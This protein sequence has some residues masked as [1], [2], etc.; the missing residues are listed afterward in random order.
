I[1][2]QPTAVPS[3]LFILNRNDT[4]S[5]FL[6]DPFLNLDINAATDYTGLFT[7]KQYGFIVGSNGILGIDSESSLHYVGLTLDAV[8]DIFVLPGFE[9]IPTSTLLKKRN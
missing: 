4:P 9:G 2:R 6:Y 3:N 5:E 8:V 7:G 1:N